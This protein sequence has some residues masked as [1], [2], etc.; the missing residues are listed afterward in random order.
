MD[1]SGSWRWE[2][3]TGSRICPRECP[4]P[5]RP[6]GAHKE[7]GGGGCLLPTGPPAVHTQG[8]G[9]QVW[10]VTQAMTASVPLHTSPCTHMH[11]ET[12][13]L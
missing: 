9:T 6:P 10:Q 11:T 4:T 3:G 12:R 13:T 5:A 7:G 1:F 8:A 2:L